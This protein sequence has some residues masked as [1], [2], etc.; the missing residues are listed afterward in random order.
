MPSIAVHLTVAEKLADK[1]AVT[2]FPSY[3]LG[4]IA[5]DSVNAEGFASREARYGAHL[6]SENYSEW[7][8]NILKYHKERQADYAE[9]PDFFKGFILHLYTDIAWDETV[10]P[11]L[12]DFLRGEGIAEDRLNEEKWNELRGF[13][14]LLSQSDGYVRS[15]SHLKQAKPLAVTTVSP[16]LM[17]QWRQKIV[18]LGYPYPPAKYLKIR[19]I[20]TAAE[21]AME[22]MKLIL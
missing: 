16:E 19:H 3:Y 4:A 9:N 18:A 2:D 13:D 12:F 11:Q 1:L 8:A 10:Q 14:S 6:R 17:E 20:D 7:K 15:I 5:P 21:R 22:Y